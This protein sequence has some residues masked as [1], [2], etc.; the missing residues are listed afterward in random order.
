MYFGWVKRHAE[1]ECN[2]LVDRLPKE[3]AVEARP[4]VYQ[5]PREVITRQKENGLRMWQRQWTKTVKGAVTKPFFPSVRNRLRQK[6]PLF[7]EFTT[8][9]T[10]HG[11]LRSYLHRFGLIDN[12][13]CPCEEERT[14]CKSLNISM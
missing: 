3:A 9:V 1:I 5:M 8:M 12:A 4:V 13:I 7:P 14:N 6:I 2:E 10:V 11:K